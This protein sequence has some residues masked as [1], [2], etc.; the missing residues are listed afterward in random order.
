MGDFNGRCQQWCNTK[1]S[2]PEGK[3]LYEF[4]ADIQLYQL[5]DKSTRPK[6]LTCLDLVFVDHVHNI[7]KIEVLPPPSMKCDHNI[8]QDIFRSE[9][10]TVNWFSLIGGMCLDDSVLIVEKMIMQVANTVIPHKNITAKSNETPW[11]NDKL[12][13]LSG[14]KRYLFKVDCRHRT[15]TTTKNHKDISKQ[16]ENECKKAKKDYFRRVSNE[17]NA[18]SKPWW[19]M[20]KNTLNKQNSTFPPLL[21]KINDELVPEPPGKAELLKKHL[22]NIC[23]MPTSELND[24][25]ILIPKSSLHATSTFDIYESN[26]FELLKK[27]DCS[28]ATAPSLSDRILKEAGAIVT[29]IITYLFNES[30]IS[31]QFPKSWKLGCVTAIFKSGDCHSQKHDSTINQLV[32]IIHQMLIAF[33]QNEPVLTAFLD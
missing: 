16:F 28:K 1:P 19:R 4:T 10:S 22:A 13:K 18:S 26:V 12:R 29:P 15:P 23:T 6:S 5:V 25:P 2:T 27:I 3:Y 7:D 33:D 9:L 17:M 24:D 31:E 21:D 32:S 20:D 11:F 30:L 14:E 8:V